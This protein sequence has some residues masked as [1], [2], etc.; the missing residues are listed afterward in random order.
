MKLVSR[1]AVFALAVVVLYAF[2]VVT[3]AKA[4]DVD[5]MLGVV[6]PVKAKKK[7]RLVYLT[8]DI[9]QA[10][11]LGAAYG[12]VDEAERSGAEVVRVFSAGGYGKVAE[13]IGQM[14]TARAMGVD[15]VILLSS[16]YNGFEKQ[17]KRLTDSG[18]KVILLGAPINSKDASL[19]IAQNEGGLGGMM[20]KHI[21]A[22][23]PGATVATLPGP[24]GVAWNKLRFE[25]FQKEAKNCNLNLVGNIY[26]GHITIEEAQSQTTDLLLKYPD[27]D[28]IYAVAGVFGVGAAQVAKRMKHKAK[29]VTAVVYEKTVEMIKDGYISMAVAEPAVLFGRASTQYAIRVLNGDQLPNMVPGI[30]D[31]P[32]VFVRNL[33]ITKAELGSYDLYNYDLPPIGWKPKQLQ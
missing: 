33:A 11:F 29:V 30:F 15:A 19:I 26:K 17:I 3:P 1:L 14:E 28:Y 20:A 6:E 12:V 2:G 9:N 24:P 31:Y 23:K 27:T 32:A 10:F 22:K 7:Y 18:I 8:A 4:A 16:A 21:C 5:R 25:G 13:Q